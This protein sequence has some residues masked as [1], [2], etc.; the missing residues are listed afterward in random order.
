MLVLDSTTCEVLDNG[1]PVGAWAS[2]TTGTGITIT[3]PAISPT[4][5]DCSL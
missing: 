2:S 4:P 1:A 5:F 3:L